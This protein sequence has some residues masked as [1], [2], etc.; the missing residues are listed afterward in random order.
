M[1]KFL[2][3]FFIVI[4]VLLAILIVT[5]FIFKGKIIK[6]AKN[7]INETV[8]AQVDF[9]DL[10]ISL[11]RNFPYLSVALND[12]S[13]VGK[14]EFENDTLLA[15]RSF[16]VAV[17]LIS[18][19]KME[20]IKVKAI[21]LDHPKIKA[22]EL[23]DG[24]VNWDIMKASETDTT[25]KV[26]T[27]ASTLN[28]KVM[29]KKF[30]II[31][32]D[33]SYIDD[34][35]NM[36]A[37]LHNFNFTLTG[38]LSQD[39]STLTI[40]SH[41]D[42]LNFLMSGV[43]YLKN[44]SLNI[45]AGIDANLKDNIYILKENE[46]A[47]NDLSL[48]FDGSVAMPNDKDINVKMKFATKKT[49]FKSVLSLVPAVYMKDFQDVQ[50]KG[51]FQLNGDIN[52]T[53]NDKVT[54]S[55]DVSLKVSQAMFKYPDLPKSADNIQVD[56]DAH[57]D[58]IQNDNTTVNV[59]KFHVEMAGNPV[60]MTLNIKTPMSDMF[61]NG[62]LKAD[63]DLASVADVIPLDSTTLTGKISTNID[64]M[65]YMSY[66]D[67][68]EYDKFKADGYLS[69]SGFDFISA[70]FPQGFKI[71]ESSFRFSPQFVQVEN[72][73]ALTGSSDINLS[74]KLENFIPYVFKD[75]TI[76][77]DF[78]FTSNKVN[79]NEFMTES[80]EETPETETDTVPLTVYEVPSNI[81]FRLLSRIDQ[82]L[83]DK[84]DIRN[85]VGTIT[86]KNSQVLL[87][88]LNM[89]L[90]KGS[91]TLSGAY[92]TTDIKNPLVDF[93]IQANT[94]DIPATFEAFSMLKSYV[95]VA[96]KAS[97]NVSLNMKYTSFLDE[98]MEPVLN[99]ITGKGRLQTN[100]ISINGSDVFDKIGS[101][102]KT[103]KFD[104]LSLRDLDIGFEIKNGK[105]YIDPFKTKVGNTELTVSGEQGIDQKMD[106]TINIS[107]PK[108]VLGKSIIDKANS[109]A[110]SLGFDLSQ[111]E[112]I[113]YDVKVLGTFSDPKI[114]LNLKN[115]AKKAIQNIKEEVK[116]EV[117]EKVNEVVD[118]KKEEAKAAVNEEVDKIMKQAQQQADV[119]RQKARDA[120]DVVRKEAN[121]NADKLLKEA[122][123]PLAKKAA[124]PMAKKMR[125]EGENKAQQ[126]ISEADKKAD[127]IMQDAQAKADKLKGGK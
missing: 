29:L 32:A 20:N 56:V 62:S 80:E 4:I 41:T 23:K 115:N 116:K 51:I 79:L 58:G 44:A 11:F 124:E 49:D 123:N 94:I 47:L 2:K 57:Y 59:N 103:D 6:I 81:D 121:A 8:N 10:N 111:S 96:R 77:G 84:L 92:N 31:G 67:N 1:K 66:I 15:F 125:Q 88:K 39:F 114:S 117:K 48:G 12:L 54:P 24:K 35:S 18:A 3:I 38:D 50:T 5:P 46:I 33:I 82:I 99:S 76:K 25:A 9:N 60:D 55:A 83:Y 95:P 113:D 26:D 106:Y 102:L 90:L 28:P 105:I 89:E 118:Q 97:G 30:E 14:D 93:D 98:H 64:M 19:I 45:K 13:V 71:Q 74:G 68:E 73:R 109:Q 17:D 108:S 22:R 107:M 16:V 126:M 85:A 78:V 101:T 65:G 112:T 75:E 27:S 100:A 40:I 120:A 53:Y 91:M 63:L 87:D 104:N 70:D 61:I 43:R 72:F 127:K 52:G 42:A 34:S 7:E 119:V 110:A 122:T 37:S 21:I 36:E 86:I 69:I